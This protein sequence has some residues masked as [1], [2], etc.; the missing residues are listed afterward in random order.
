MN[1]LQYCYHCHTKRCGHAIGEDEE[2]VISAVN[3]GIKRLGFS[4]HVILPRGFE[5]PTIRGYSDQLNDYLNSIKS[6]KVKYKKDV[7]I[8]VGFE[9]EYYPQMVD[10]YKDLLK[11]KI[12]FLILGQ[13]CYLSDDHFC[14][15]FHNDIR[16]NRLDLYTNHIVE[17]L[18]T[19]LFKYL[20]HPD[21]FMHSYPCWN[22]ETEKY[23]KIILSTCEELDI[24]VE[25]NINGLIRRDWNEVGHAYPNGDF[26]E[27]ARQ[28]NVR[29]IIGIDAHSPGAFNEEDIKKTLDFINKHHLKIDYDY[30][31]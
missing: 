26:F 12:D 14:W 31:I 15:Y 29:F 2:Y 21:L 20:A 8:L 22:E 6:L 13:H 3:L 10:Y 11:D 17:G 7:E 23:A 25:I 30:R 28:Y 9:A 19:G 24:P 5:Q 16:K 27:L 1:K 18:K 4:D